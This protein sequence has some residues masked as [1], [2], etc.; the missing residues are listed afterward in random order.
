[1]LPT[2]HSPLAQWLA[3][4]ERGGKSRRQRPSECQNVSISSSKETLSKSTLR[5]I[6]PRCFGNYM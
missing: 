3:A 5:G 4:S 6:R 2:T 1:M